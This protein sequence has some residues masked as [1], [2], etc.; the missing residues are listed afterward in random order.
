M[1]YFNV[2]SGADLI[3]ELPTRRTQNWNDNYLTNFTTPITQ[4]DHTGSGKGRL[5]ATAAISANAINGTK[6]LLAN[7]EYLRGRN[8]ADSAN[9]NIIKVNASDKIELGVDLANNNIINDTYFKGR[10]NADSDYV[11]LIK[12]NTSDKIATGADF[13]NIAM[14]GNTYIQGRNNADSG[15]INAFK[16]NAS[17]YIE[18][19][20]KTVHNGVLELKSD[21][22]EVSKTFTIANNQT[23]ANVTGLTVSEVA[24]KSWRIS[25]ERLGP[26]RTQIL[27]QK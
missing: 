13:A 10:N 11:S 23:N 9:V 15:Y 1:P 25:P 7:D 19:G 26:E 22:L 3:L 27:G 5:I 6:I 17:D 14:I 12:V 8:N 16:I 20:V 24:G 18:L 21:R 4:H 2:G